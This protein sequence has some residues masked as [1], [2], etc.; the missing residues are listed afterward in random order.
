MKLKKVCLILSLF[1]VQNYGQGQNIIQNGDFEQFTICPNGMDLI[2][3]ATFWNRAGTGTSDYFNQCSNNTYSDV[4]FNYWGFQ[5]AHSGLGY[6]GICLYDEYIGTALNYRE[7]IENELNSTLIAGA[8]YSFEMYINLVDSC[9]YSTNDIGVYFSDTT[10]YGV[11]DYFPIDV[12]PQIINLNG[13][14]PDSLSWLKIT[15]DYIATG[16]ENFIVIGNFKSDS[17][18]NLALSN[19]NTYETIAYILVDD[20]SLSLST[21]IKSDEH[22]DKFNIYPNPFINELEIN[23]STQ[24][25]A[26]ISLYDLSLHKLIQ[27]EFV[28]DIKLDLSAFKSGIYFYELTNSQTETIRG[29]LVKLE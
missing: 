28:N 6:S 23:S 12:Y 22:L 19:S 5:G 27:Q 3:L 26:T 4:P 9:R 1:F 16:G 17:S 29:K 21:G 15:G 7:Y 13:I 10:C 24:H 14:Y 8:T 18:T 11:P 2:Q 20:V 25:Q